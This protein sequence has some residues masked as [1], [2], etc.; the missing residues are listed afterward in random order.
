MKPAASIPG[1]IKEPTSVELPVE[2]TQAAILAPQS[3][4]RE[5]AGREAS[6]QRM[7]MMVSKCSIQPPGTRL[8]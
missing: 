8:W 6:S 3:A 5:S 2:T 1:L 4:R 7:S